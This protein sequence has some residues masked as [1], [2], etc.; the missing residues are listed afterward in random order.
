MDRYTRL[1]LT[2]VTHRHLLYSAWNSAQSYV[3]AWTGGES[4]RME[5]RMCPAESPCCPPK[6][7]TTLLIGC[8]PTQNK[9]FKNKQSF[10]PTEFGCERNLWKHLGPDF[11]GFPSAQP[12]VDCDLSLK[13]PPPSDPGPGPPR[14]SSLLQLPALSQTGFRSFLLPCSTS[15]TTPGWKRSSPAFLKDL[16]NLGRNR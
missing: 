13:T 11:S 2:W 7:I 3:A 5:A 4:G 6:T 12:R 1:C 10:S 14:C 16:G 9:K 8:T 15:Y